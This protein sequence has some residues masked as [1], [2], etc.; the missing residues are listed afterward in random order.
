MLLAISS[1]LQAQTPK[2]CDKLIITGVEYMNRQ[3]YVKSLELLTKAKAIAKKN[4]WHKQQF[5]AINIIGAN[6]FSMLD[7]GEALNNYLAA[8]TIA[9]KELDENSEMIVLNNIAIL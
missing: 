8:Y 4:K 6:Y 1:F 3:D 2:E 7:Y 9:I 5:L